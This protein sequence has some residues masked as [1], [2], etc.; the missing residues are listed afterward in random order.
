[1][2]ASNARCLA[3]LAGLLV[4]VPTA[5]AAAQ[6]P[7][8][9]DGPSWLSDRS[10]VEGRGIR[11]G[12]LELHPGIG[13]EAGYDSNV[14]L[15]SGQTEGPEVDS[16]I[17]RVSP[18]LYLSTMGD[19]RRGDEARRRPQQVRFR[20]GVSAS[21]YEYFS[22]PE[23]RNLSAD[24]SLRLDLFPESTWQVSLFEDFT[25][26]I[27]PFTNSAEDISYARDRNRVGFDIGFVPGGGVLEYRLGYAMGVD[28]FE[29]SG[30][31]AY[32]NIAHEI[33]LRGRWRFLPKTAFSYE[34][35]LT[36]R[37]Y[38]DPTEAL[39]TR[40]D[41]TT[42]GMRLGLVGLVSTR[43][44][45]NLTVGYIAGFYA[46]SAGNDLQNVTGQADLT[47]AYSDS[48]RFRLGYLRDSQNAYFGNFIHR[49]QGTLA[50]QHLIAG[51]LLLGL[52][53]SA[54]LVQYDD[55]IYA[56][57][58]SDPGTTVPVNDRADIL[59]RGAL[60]IEY[61][62]VHWLGATLTASYTTN[63]TDFEYFLP[64]PPGSGVSVPDPGEYNKI[65]AW[66]GVRAAF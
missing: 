38:M 60:N 4:A 46:G 16:F 15:S 13:V 41:S 5:S 29:E 17:L 30:F 3:I 62:F 9:H 39:T 14:F 55:T 11:A 63:I 33:F 45:I 1:M 19:E 32:N 51:R 18:H 22:L 61:R 6:Q 20:G 34:G 43:I 50:W 59:I 37:N 28:I 8:G 25:R 2:R 10:R 44:S 21:Y 47:W 35:T 24:L 40:A 49:D 12:R 42:L 48:G 53:G 27:R 54:S 7:L 65:E 58:P 66:L 57:D 52:E 64:G 56:P 26:G 36:I 31:D 23:Q